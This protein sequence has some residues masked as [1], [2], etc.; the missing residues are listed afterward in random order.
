M[1]MLHRVHP[2]PRHREAAKQVY[3]AYREK[4]SGYSR[5]ELL[6]LINKLMIEVSPGLAMAFYELLQQDER[7]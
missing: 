7:V 4:L 6:D 2:A 3:E 1:H 5:E